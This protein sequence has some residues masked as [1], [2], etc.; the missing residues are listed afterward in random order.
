[1]TP[2]T[3]ISPTGPEADHGTLLE[4][5]RRSAMQLFARRTAATAV[6]VAAGSAAM[7]PFADAQ[8][9][10]DSD[11]VNFALNLE[12][13]EAEFYLRALPG[14]GLQAGDTTGVGTQGTVTGGSAV[15]FRSN[16]IRQYAQVLAVDEQAHVRFLRATLGSAA[17]AEPTINLSTSFTNLA[18]AAGLIQS[19]QTFNPLSDEVSLLLGA[20]ILEEV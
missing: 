15:P 13:L 12:S 11:I 17:I 3:V 7:A 14:Q 16:A 2:P 4:A 10:T 1:M 19:G 18:I 8:A 5:G 6:A 9:V 20:Y